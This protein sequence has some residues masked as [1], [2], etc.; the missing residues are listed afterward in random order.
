MI[1]RK[2]VIDVESKG[3]QTWLGSL[4]DDGSKGEMMSFR[5]M[6]TG[7]G[8]EV[9]PRNGRKNKAGKVETRIREKP[10]CKPIDWGLGLYCCDGE[11][12]PL[13]SADGESPM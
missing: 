13:L 1:F 12:F 8:K 2:S 5:G 10:L 6:G 9:H 11:N 7:L 4:H 3:I